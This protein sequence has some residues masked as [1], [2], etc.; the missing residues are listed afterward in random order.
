LDALSSLEDITCSASETGSCLFIVVIAEETYKLAF[1]FFGVVA[2]DALDA[3]IALLGLTVG[4]A[5]GYRR[6]AFSVLENKAC[7]A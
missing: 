2:I 5:S 1:S 6:L 4:E 3:D 7:V